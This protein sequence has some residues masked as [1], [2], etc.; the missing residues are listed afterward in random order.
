M[1]RSR[2]TTIVRQESFDYEVRREMEDHYSGH[3]VIKEAELVAKVPEL[4]R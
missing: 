4:I 1:T 2:L 3:L